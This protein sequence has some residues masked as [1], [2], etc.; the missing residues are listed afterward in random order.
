MKRWVEILRVG[1]WFYNTR[2]PVKDFYFRDSRAPI[3]VSVALANSGP[4]QVELIQQRND[5]P[6]FY[7]EFVAAHGEGLQHVAYWTSHFDEDMERA[8]GHGLRPV[9]GGQVGTNGRYAYFDT[10]FHPGSV[11]ELS[12]VSGLKGDLFRRIRDPIRD[13]PRLS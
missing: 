13:F 8:A 9:M 11:V 10:G 6:S 1:P 4:V 2:V 12:E 7:R 5:A 3:E